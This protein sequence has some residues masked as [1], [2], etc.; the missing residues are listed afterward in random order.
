MGLEVGLTLTSGVTV[1]VIDT[2]GPGIVALG[3]LS[4]SCAGGVGTPIGP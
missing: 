2:D 1:G 4:G 3:F